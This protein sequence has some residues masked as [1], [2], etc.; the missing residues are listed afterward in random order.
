VK[1]LKGSEVDLSNIHHPKKLV[2][3]VEQRGSSGTTP[4]LK[5]GAK[6]IVFLSELFGGPVATSDCPVMTLTP[7]TLSATS[8][9]VTEDRSGTSHQ[10]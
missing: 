4:L 7:E 1:R 5:F 2:L 9:G 8:K 3:I 6:P 10:K